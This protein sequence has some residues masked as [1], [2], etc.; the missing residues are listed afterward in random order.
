VSPAVP[1]LGFV[2]LPLQ[3]TFGSGFL[4]GMDSDAG[5]VTAHLS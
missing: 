4:A 1:R 3:N 2:G 5:Y